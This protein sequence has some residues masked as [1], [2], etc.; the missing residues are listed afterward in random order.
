MPLGIA[1]LAIGLYDGK[2]ERK[3]YRGYDPTDFSQEEVQ[4]NVRIMVPANVKDGSG[5]WPVTVA[6]NATRAY[7]ESTFFVLCTATETVLDGTTNWV[8]GIK[9]YPYMLTARMTIPAKSIGTTM[10][11]QASDDMG[12]HTNLTK[13]ALYTDGI[14]VASAK[15]T[16]DEKWIQVTPR[17][18]AR[19]QEIGFTWMNIPQGS[20]AS[21]YQVVW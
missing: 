17:G 6:N 16:I 1:L 7:G 8:L 12:P 3:Q 4:Q 13:C 11:T 19:A 18:A 9:Q 5:E 21:D 14:T 10:F 15:E 2:Q 20:N